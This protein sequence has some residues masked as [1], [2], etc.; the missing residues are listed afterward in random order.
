MAVSEYRQT[1]SGEYKWWRALFRRLPLVIAE[2][3]DFGPSEDD[4]SS[5]RSI[6]F[7]HPRRA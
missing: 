2:T 3:P 1:R 7:C 6:R 5:A 4:D